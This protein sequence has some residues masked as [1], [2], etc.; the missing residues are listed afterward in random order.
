MATDY[1]KLSDEELDAI[2]S[3]KAPAPVAAHS[4]TG[5]PADVRTLGPGPAKA[6]TDTSLGMPGW[7]LALAGA[8]GEL[9][10]MAQGLKEKAQLAF[11]PDNYNEAQDVKNRITA[12][13]TDRRK[14]MEALYN[15]PEAVAGRFGAQLIPAMAAPARLPA[16]V[17][18]AALTGFAKP[19]SEKASGFGSELTGSAAHG[20]VDALS[21]YGVGKG[22]ELAGHGVGALLGR[23]TPEGEKALAT[24]DAAL[25]LG[26]PP[27]SVGQLFP[28]GSAASV[29]R[30]IPGMGYGARTGAQADVLKAKLDRPLQLPEGSASDVGRAYVDELAAAGAERMR[31]GTAKYKAVDD[32]V[33][34]NGLGQ[35]LPTYTARTITNTNNPG[36]EVASGLLGRYGFDAGSMVGMKASALGKIPL[37]FE[38]YHTMRVA[39]NKALNTLERGMATAEKMGSSIPAENKAAKAYL[40]DLKTA[41]DN[42]AERWA[43][44]HASNEDALNLYR[45]ATQYYRDVV[46][47]TVLDNP[48]ARKAMSGS[49][50]F[51]TGREGLAA[52]QSEAGA[53]FVERLK[54][55]MS[56]T[57]LDMTTVLQGLPDVRRL[58]LSQDMRLP[59]T[60]GGLSQAAKVA[61]GHPLALVETAIS[62]I[63]G[64]RALSES[65][66][67]TRLLG[68]ENLA[69]E[70]AASPLM[71]LRNMAPRAAWGAAQYPQDEGTRKVRQLGGMR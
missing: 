39:T 63:P 14:K 32:F 55:T 19:G 58:V 1:S 67:A 68:A 7:Q 5:N 61:L 37:R 49:R 50:G 28:R 53:P 65:R 30:T 21:M 6:D 2:I 26:L 54:P 15:N 23:Y 36:Y 56:P 51:K 35:L 17:G 42:D 18:L 12:D 3:G 22:L 34:A 47:P 59:L 71:S 70:S 20:G 69:E 9:N 46:A 8:G 10:E 62:R 27:T 64:L 48:I 25:R 43:A 38:D 60:E 66:A 16:Q 41:L 33:N 57:G 24:K 31:L 40:Q 44:R 13:R 45:D 11:L 29:E 4:T 52:S